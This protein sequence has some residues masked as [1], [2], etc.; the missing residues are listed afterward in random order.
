MLQAQALLEQSLSRDVNW[1]VTSE[2]ARKKPEVGKQK[3]SSVCVCRPG[4]SPPFV[5]S[6][7]QDG[8]PWHQLPAGGMFWVA[9]RK[10]AGKIRVR[11]KSWL[12]LSCQRQFLNCSMSSCLSSLLLFLSVPAKNSNSQSWEGAAQIPVRDSRGLA[13]S[14]ESQEHPLSHRAP[15]ANQPWQLGILISLLSAPLS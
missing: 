6:L 4:A 13:V 10:D 5:L 8:I 12:C 3:T 2:R 15:D 11:V 7:L 14:R 1:K 9:A